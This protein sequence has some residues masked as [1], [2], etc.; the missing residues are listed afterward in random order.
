MDSNPTPSH[1]IHAQAHPLP[2]QK[3]QPSN[4][5]RGQHTAQLQLLPAT[6]PR[7]N[8]PPGRIEQ[9]P[10]SAASFLPSWMRTPT[11]T[12]VR[13]SNKR[14]TSDGSGKVM[15]AADAAAADTK[16]GAQQQRGQHHER[17]SA[18]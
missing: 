2:T 18:G 15:M 7:A 4:A 6:P 9:M 8:R 14:V 16:Q 12:A 10:A 13:N 11:R 1:H 3:Q 17:P 5:T